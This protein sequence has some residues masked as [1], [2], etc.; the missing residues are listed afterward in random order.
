[1]NLNL[2]F[3]SLLGQDSYTEPQR[4]ELVENMHYILTVGNDNKTI[5]QENRNNAIIEDK[6]LHGIR[7]F[8]SNFHQEDFIQDNQSEF[9][10]GLHS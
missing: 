5:S 4:E 6:D 10:K 2:E 9:W 7:R 8:Q 1:M 3:S